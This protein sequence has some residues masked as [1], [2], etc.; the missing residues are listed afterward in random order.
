MLCWRELEAWL[1]S[2]GLSKSQCV[3]LASRALASDEIS[4]G[5]MP[6]DEKGDESGVIPDESRRDAGEAEE[7]EGAAKALQQSLRNEAISREVTETKVDEDDEFIESLKTL[8]ES[9]VA[10]TIQSRW[11]RLATA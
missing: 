2:K 10:I 6:R 4:F 11:K 8:E 9:L 5:A 1:K 7:L 3:S